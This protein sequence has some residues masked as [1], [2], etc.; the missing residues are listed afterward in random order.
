M[1][2]TFAVTV[3]RIVRSAL[4]GFSAVG[5]VSC[6]GALSARRTP[7]TAPRIRDELIVFFMFC[8]FFVFIVTRSPPEALVT[9]SRCRLA[10]FAL[11]LLLQAR[12][13]AGELPMLAGAI[14]A[15]DGL[16]V[17]CR[18][19]CDIEVCRFAGLR[20]ELRIRQEGK[21]CDR[22]E[23]RYRFV[24]LDTRVLDPEVGVHT[25]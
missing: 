14:N 24:P 1:A 21:P 9:S 22:V 10:R 8:V 6:A 17:R 7:R 13:S 15:P 2:S 12:L 18:V 16:A 11:A 19:P 25:P 20:R 3:T 23:R 5:F 4:K